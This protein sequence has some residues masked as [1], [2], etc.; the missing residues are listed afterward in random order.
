MG[1]S[2]V[3]FDSRIGHGKAPALN[4]KNV[5]GVRLLFKIRGG[6][7]GPADTTQRRSGYPLGGGRGVPGGSQKW[8]HK[9]ENKAFSK[10]IPP[11]D[12]PN[13]FGGTPPGGGSGGIGIPPGDGG[14]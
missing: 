2:S 11:S 7:R 5:F 3:V 6:R 9:K 4:W 8:G 10:T 13:V 12:R 14:Y 1:L